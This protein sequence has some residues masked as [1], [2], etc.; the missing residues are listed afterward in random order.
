[1]YRRRGSS[2]A[3]NVFIKWRL[4]R[5]EGRVSERMQRVFDDGWQRLSGRGGQRDV[6]QLVYFFDAAHFVDYLDQ[7]RSADYAEHARAFARGQRADAEAPPPELA[8]KQWQK[9]RLARR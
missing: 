8:R 5:F 6:G 4:R 3:E 2:L 1:R 7:F 9:E